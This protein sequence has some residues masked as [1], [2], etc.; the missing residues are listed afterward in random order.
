LFLKVT[1]I[2]TH[3]SPSRQFYDAY[4]AGEGQPI[5]SGAWDPESVVCRVLKARGNTGRVEFWRDDRPY[6][7]L[8]IKDLVK[9]ASTRI[10]EGERVGPKQGQFTPYV[11]GSLTNLPKAVALID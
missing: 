4:L 9:Y 2:P 1:L 10:V 8:I 11:V 5:V 6:P 3:R 7:C